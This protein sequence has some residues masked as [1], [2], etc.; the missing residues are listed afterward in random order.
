MKPRPSPDMAPRDPAAEAK[1]A[2]A[3]VSAVLSADPSPGHT[4]VTSMTDASLGTSKKAAAGAKPEKGRAAP[5]PRRRKV[6]IDADTLFPLVVWV[7]LHARIPGIHGWLNLISALSDQA[8]TNFG[9]SGMALAL[10][11]AAASHICSMSPHDFCLDIPSGLQSPGTP[12]PPSSPA[13]PVTRVESPNSS[14]PQLD[15]QC[16]LMEAGSPVMESNG[17]ARK[18][19]GG[20]GDGSE[21]VNG[22]SKR[23]SCSSSSGQNH[24]DT[25][26]A[27]A[28]AP[29][30]ACP[31]CK[32]EMPREVQFCRSCGEKVASCRDAKGALT[33][34]IV[35]DAEV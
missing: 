35:V 13:H 6:D 7:F 14:A 3:V 1:A 29:D 12:R 28:A 5:A 8:V 22:S 33:A 15:E 19:R 34:Y 11:E 16:P 31:V 30:L 25:A 24:K 20:G 17:C 18:G 2:V 27:A 23:S 32:A 21:G 9:E 10:A 26:A 4:R